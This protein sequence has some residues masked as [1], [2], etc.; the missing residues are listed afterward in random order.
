MNIEY[1]RMIM[2]CIYAYRIQSEVPIL[3]LHAYIQIEISRKRER[4]ILILDLDIKY[5][6]RTLPVQRLPPAS[7]QNIRVALD[8]STLWR[9]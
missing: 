8:T 4:Y 2:I 9:I 1:T 6:D 7:A 5:I 3:Y